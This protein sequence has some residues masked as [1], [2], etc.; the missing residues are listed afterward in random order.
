MSDRVWLV[1][2]KH[3]GEWYPCWWDVYYKRREAENKARELR[4]Q[5]Y[6]DKQGFRAVEYARKQK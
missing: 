1:E 5:G 3:D 6:T 2:A 4:K